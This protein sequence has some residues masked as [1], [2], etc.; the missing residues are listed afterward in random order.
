MRFAL[1][2]SH[3][4]VITLFFFLNALI[5]STQCSGS[6]PCTAGSFN[7]GYKQIDP[8]SIVGAVF[9]SG[10]T[11]TFTIGVGPGTTNEAANGD[12]EYVTLILIVMAYLNIA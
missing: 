7:P 1:R 2:M 11:R 6:G 5:L 9:F 8:S 12:V 4:Y 10:Q 3:K